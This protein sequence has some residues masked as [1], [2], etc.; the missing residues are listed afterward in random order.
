[1]VNVRFFLCSAQSS[2]TKTTCEMMRPSLRRTARA[3]LTPN[4]EADGSGLSLT[5][6]FAIMLSRHSS[7]ASPT[8]QN[9]LTKMDKTAT[10]ALRT[11]SLF[12]S[13]TTTLPQLGTLQVYLFYFYLTGA[14]SFD[15]LENMWRRIYVDGLN[16]VGPTEFAFV[17]ECMFRW[18][19]HA[20]V[21]DEGVEY[22][23][24]RSRRHPIYTMDNPTGH[25]NRGVMV[26]GFV[27]RDMNQ[28]EEQN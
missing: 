22:S 7:P 9:G 25:D 6:P 28:G 24:G 4:H 15:V 2:G 17:D 8:H 5:D 18:H 14:V 11:F 16:S 26:R 12:R 20:E 10:T 19:N 13:F 23:S 3:D 21:S 1:M 27:A